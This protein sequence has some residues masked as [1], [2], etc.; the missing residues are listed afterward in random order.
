MKNAK[1]KRQITLLTLVMA[2]GVAVYLNW[3]YAKTETSI[4]SSEDTMA[5][6]GAVEGEENAV[7]VQD[8]VLEALPDKNYGDAQLVSAEKTDEYFEQARL[9]R[10]KTRDDAL[11]K[12]QTSLKAAN[13]TNEEKEKLTDELSL[14]IAAI[15]A[16]SDI[17]NLVK[18]KGFI[19]CVVFINA[20]EVDVAVK[21]DGQPLNEQSVAVIRDIVLGKVDTQAQNITIV[22]VE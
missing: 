11:D 5:V 10:E 1:T 19:D 16:E 7:P 8:S 17:E 6:I 21:T 3:Q 4:L 9:T 20:N 2:L 13:L 15:T 18:A 14:V 22:E 12:L